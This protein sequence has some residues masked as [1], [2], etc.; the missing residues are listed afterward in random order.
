MKRVILVLTLVLAFTGLTVNADII[1]PPAKIVP[2]HYL[3]DYPK[4]KNITPDNIE[5]MSVLRY[6]EAGVSEK[7]IEDKNEITAYYNFL[8]QITLSKETGQGCTDNTTIYRFQL[9]DGTNAYI[10]IEC[11]WVVLDGKNYYFNIPSKRNLRKRI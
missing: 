6:T 1:A 9:K 8:K 2:V 7:K 5:S 11:E 10:E 4:Y 3:M